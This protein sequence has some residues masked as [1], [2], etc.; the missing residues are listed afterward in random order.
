[1]RFNGAYGGSSMTQLL[2]QFRQLAREW[3]KEPMVPGLHLQP[4]RR[5]PRRTDQEGWHQAIQGATRLWAT[6]LATLGKSKK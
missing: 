5:R 4:T 2:F 1:V 6:P 3:R